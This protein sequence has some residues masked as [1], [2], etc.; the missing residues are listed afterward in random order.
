MTQLHICTAKQAFAV[1]A[2]F[3]VWMLWYIVSYTDM[4]ERHWT[5]ATTRSIYVYL[6]TFT[7]WRLSIKFIHVYYLLVLHQSQRRYFSL[8]VPSCT[9]ITQFNIR[10]ISV[11][12]YT[13][14][15]GVHWS[16][17]DVDR[18][19]GK[20]ICWSLKEVWGSVWL[21]GGLQ[22]TSV[23][24]LS[25]WHNFFHWGLTTLQFLID[26]SKLRVVAFLNCSSSSIIDGCWDDTYSI[27]FESDNYY[28]SVV[29]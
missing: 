7:T 8:E 2:L 24:I 13:W 1:L 20:M 4:E 6:L 28:D 15:F 12:P 19:V 25:G 17:Q 10:D 18:E 14:L 21:C 5:I 27:R 23:R 9:F 11:T 29:V 16:K 3:S 26:K 22:V